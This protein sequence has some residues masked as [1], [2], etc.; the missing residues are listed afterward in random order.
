MF[1]GRRSEIPRTQ[2]T[3]VVD[4]GKSNHMLPF[5]FVYNQV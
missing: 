1:V 2:V 4:P 5:D 3:F